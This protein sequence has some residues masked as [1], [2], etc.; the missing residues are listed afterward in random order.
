MIDTC[1]CNNTMTYKKAIPSE[2]IELGDIVINGSSS[3]KSE[4]FDTLEQQLSKNQ[5][6]GTEFG[7]GTVFSGEWDTF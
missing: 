5:E 1:D 7:K 6:T 4:V 2:I 3:N